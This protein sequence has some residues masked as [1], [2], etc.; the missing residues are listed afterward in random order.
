MMLSDIDG[1]NFVGANQELCQLREKLFKDQKFKESLTS[2]KI[3]WTFNPPSSPHFRGIFEV[4][5]KAAKTAILAILGNADVNDEEL[6]T[7]FTGAESL[8][9][10]RP[11]TYQSANPH[12]STLLTPNHFLHGQSGGQF[13][14]EVDEELNS[15]PTKRWRRV[16]ELVRHV[17]HRWMREWVPS[18]SSRKKWYHFSKNLRVGDIVLLISIENTRAHWPLETVIEVYPGKDGYVR[19]VKLEVG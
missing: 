1:T 8:M 13:A 7:A 4:M 12:D 15:N 16:Q 10:S 17:W 11:L 6:M 19:C 9:N 5:I 14:P 2:K 18:L 3:E